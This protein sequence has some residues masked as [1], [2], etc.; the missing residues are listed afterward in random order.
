MYFL[1]NW[2]QQIQSGQ[3]SEGFLAQKEDAKFL[4]QF[5]LRD[6]GH[7]GTVVWL[8]QWQTFKLLFH[9]PLAE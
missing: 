7:G 4:D 1:E 8:S 2:E 5:I 6:S 9:G 3:S